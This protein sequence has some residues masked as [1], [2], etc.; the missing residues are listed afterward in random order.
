MA[1]AP[2]FSVIGTSN[3]AAGAG[4]TEAARYNTSVQYR[5]A[6]GP[7]RLAALYQFGGYDQGNGSDG[8]YEAQIGADFGGFSFDAVGGK[9][10]DVVSLSNFGESPL[11]SGVA[12]NDLKATLSDNT[13]G[14]IMTKYRYDALTFYTGFEY[15]LF[16]NPSNSYPNGFKTLGGYFVLPGYMNSTAFD[17]N[18]ILRVFW[19]GAKY[20]V[21]QDLDIAA[22]IYHYYQNDY[23]TSTCTNG[24]LS[25]SSCGGTLDAASV[26]IDYRPAKRLDAYAGVMWSQVTGGL[27]SGYL[28]H[29]NL[30]PTIGLRVEF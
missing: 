23:N 13:T 2:A 5:V 24:G 8:A 11:P 22:A 6:V 7:L 25:A 26:M 19:S 12:A 20:A 9:V 16:R 4:D 21:T 14:V 15:I 17:N 1:A 29:V 28:N 3:T 18:K 10:K 30:G 27:A